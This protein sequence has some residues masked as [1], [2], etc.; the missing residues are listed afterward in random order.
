MYIVDLRKEHPLS[1]VGG[2]AIHLSELIRN[3]LPVPEAHCLPARVYH[4]YV[5]PVIGEIED[6]REVKKRISDIQFEQDLLEELN[7]FLKEH[8]TIAVRS[9]GIMEDMEERSFAGQYDSFLNISRIEDLVEAIKRCW[10]S[11]WSRETQTYM[12]DN[13]LEGKMSMAVVLQE[14]IS[15]EVSGVLF[16]VNPLTGIDTHMLIESVW[17][18]GEG[19]VTG[20]VSPDRLIY[21]WSSMEL[22]EKTTSPQSHKYEIR[23]EGGTHKI[24]TTDDEKEKHSITESTLNELVHLGL[25][26]GRQY[27]YPQDIEW[28][29]EKGK[30]Y[31]L[32]TRPLTS[33]QFSKDFGQWTN[34][35][36][37]EVFPGFH[38]PLSFSLTGGAFT[39]T[40]HE[41]L[42][43][44][45]IW[46]R[47]PVER[48]KWHR[49]IFGRTYW[50]VSAVKDL[51]VQVPG[52]NER[53]FD[54]TTGIPVNYEGDGRTTPWSLGRIIWALPVLLALERE[55]KTFWKKASEYKNSFEKIYPPLL[56]RALDAKNLNDNELEDF[57]TELFKLDLEC[58]RIAQYTSFLA[59]QSQDDFHVMLDKLNKKADEKISFSRLFTGLENV[60]T[61]T[62]LMELEKL[63]DRLKGITTKDLEGVNPSDLMGENTP[64][65]LKPIAE[66]I[67]RFAWMAENDEDLSCPRWYDDIQTPVQLIKNLL[68][69]GDG[70]Q[71][72]EEKQRD[73]RLEEEEKVR[74]ELNRGLG[75][76][77]IMGKS[78][79]WKQVELVRKYSWWREETREMLARIYFLLHLVLEERFRRFEKE[80]LVDSHKDMY[81]LTYT[82]L[83][84]YF[85]GGDRSVVDTAIRNYNLTK[86]L[87]RNYHP[88]NTIGSGVPFGQVEGDGD[89][90]GVGCSNGTVTG[91]VR[92]LKSVSQISEIQRGEIAVVPHTNPGWTPIFSLISG[93][94]MEEG[95]LLS[96]GSVVARE[97]GIPAVI[98]VKHA[99]NILMDGEEITID[100]DTGKIRRQD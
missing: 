17:G 4:Q 30:V 15:P 46:R 22:V 11:M 37:V 6:L 88:P 19:V 45:K 8:T 72:S 69:Q 25:R 38:N 18:L 35:N 33:I 26:V 34:A 63:M 14:Q 49:L 24:P 12:R 83:M 70:K 78:S 10:S 36:F 67:M 23:E 84:D 96:H 5:D 44:I 58:N 66:Y 48:E 89:L 91:K 81:S 99:T 77:N 90:S 47:P 61:A 13:K 62:P 75:R 29:V 54:I 51:L 56:D 39:T 68:T 65:K 43:N 76:L 98:Q 41:Y 20:E 100:G 27:G 73:V 64:E 94:V 87:Y 80:G 40:L 79:F 21:D 59:T 1:E 2:K 74:R 86:E 50:K 55:Y 97:Y 52:F 53:S 60:K 92:V 7:Q 42:I 93:I 85:E 3:E 82:D 31:L 95:G 32:Q 57:I 16:T 71:R 9:S 28:A